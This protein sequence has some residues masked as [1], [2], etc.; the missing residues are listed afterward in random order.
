MTETIS[1]NYEQ[2][3]PYNFPVIDEEI[4]SS[5][6]ERFHQ[7]LESVMTQRPRVN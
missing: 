7:L 5:A 3:G 4:G 2:F 1:L 6:E